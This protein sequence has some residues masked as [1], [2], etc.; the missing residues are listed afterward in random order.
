MS[1]LWLLIKSLTV[2]NPQ[3]EFMESLRIWGGLNESPVLFR[4]VAT[5]VDEGGR[6]AIGVRRQAKAEDRSDVCNWGCVI[7]IFAIVP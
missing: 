4:R 6:N 3:T 1:L 5:N 2:R 7:C